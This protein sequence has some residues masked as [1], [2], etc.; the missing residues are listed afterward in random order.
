M[1][2]QLLQNGRIINQFDKL[3]G[4][5][6]PKHAGIHDLFETELLIWIQVRTV[7]SK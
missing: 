1:V 5:L 2:I 7:G 6:R 3:F 4:I